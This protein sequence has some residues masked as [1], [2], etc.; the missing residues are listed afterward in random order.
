MNTLYYGD[1]LPILKKHI[2][3]ESVDL[4]YLDPPFNSNRNYNVLFKD[5]SGTEADAQITAFEDT[6]HWTQ[7]AERLYHDVVTASLPVSG[8][9][10][11][12]RFTIGT[13]QMMAYLV[14]MTAR[15]IELHRVLRPTGSLYLHCDPTASHYLKIVLDA[16]FG[17]QNFRNEVI[18]KRTSAHSSAKRYGPIHD[19][20]LFYSKSDSY[21]WN[22]QHNPY[23][24]EYIRHFY[25]NINQD[26]RHFT[27]G[28]LTGAGVRYGET[29]LQW[30]GIDVTAKG[31]HWMLPPRELDKLDVDGKIYW[32]SKGGM[33]R[34]RRYLDE[35]EG[36]L[37]QDIFDDIFPIGAQA[38]ERLGYPT[39]KPIALLERIIKASSNEGDV[40]L[41]PFCGCGT[42]VVA[43]QNLNRKWIG[44]DITHLSIA[45]MK[46]RLT[47]SF[48]L[49]P[50]KDYS[51]IGEPEDV[52]SA[53]QLANDDRYQFQWWA[54]S[55][56]KARPAG[57][58]G[59]KK[60][61]ADKGIDGLITFLDD[62]T[63]K[64]KRVIVQ[65]KSGHIK[66]GDVRDLI[67]VLEREKAEIGVFI[68]LNDPTRDMLTEAVSA[69]FYRSEGWQRDYP[70][71]QILTIAELLDGKPA[72][73][74]PTA[75]T[76]KN[77]NS[78]VPINR[79]QIYLNL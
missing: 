50:K 75:T 67:G 64:P 40:V 21:N 38:A 58:G 27:L 13:N 14:M 66:S 55:L 78:V 68:T 76:F 46:Y 23:D 72:Q 2:P 32:P 37:L 33:P 28:D 61:G 18:W 48:H 73:L 31:R 59:E 42:A 15:L 12:L 22:P 25:R 39:Q 35:M 17:A 41:D 4:V 45:L 10:G 77:G 74:P 52:S 20:V 43:A 54:L 7:D 5:E 24:K 65:V 44:I 11:S 71:V 1:N 36:V 60:K 34:L 49:E 29:G 3:S 6:W 63:G 30:R 79:D 70:K 9:L 53:R 47:D 26:G 51:V 19:V 69:G 16:V 62:Q 8:L 56:I 57:A